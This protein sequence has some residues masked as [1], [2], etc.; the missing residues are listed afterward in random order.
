VFRRSRTFKGSIG[1]WDRLEKLGS[2]IARR[3][4]GA[5]L[6][7]ERSSEA[8]S[9]VIETLKVRSDNV[10]T[11]RVAPGCAMLRG[12]RFPMHLGQ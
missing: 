3:E 9:S 7:L 2:L 1:I 11:V 5:S 10:L 6:K 12:K 8:P 4:I